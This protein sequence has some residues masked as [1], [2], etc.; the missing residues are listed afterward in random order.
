MIYKIS[1]FTP[2]KYI[3]CL[4]K[5]INKK[6][7]EMSLKGQNRT[8]LKWSYLVTQVQWLTGRTCCFQPS[9]ITSSWT[10]QSESYYPDMMLNPFIESGETVDVI[11]HEIS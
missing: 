2:S 1:K 11:S 5:N 4:R 7:L 8:M 6:H 10:N 3:G 9:G